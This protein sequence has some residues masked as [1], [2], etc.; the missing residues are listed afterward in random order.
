M[1]CICKVSC[2]FVS[3]DLGRCHAVDRPK[4]AGAAA[5]EQRG[6][7]DGMSAAPQLACD[8]SMIRCA[9]QVVA[10]CPLL[11]NE[12]WSVPMSHQRVSALDA[13]LQ[14][15][16]ALSQKHRSPLG[17]PSF[18][19][20]CVSKPS[21]H[22]SLKIQGVRRQGHA[23]L[24]TFSCIPITASCEGYHQLQIGS[25]FGQFDGAINT[26]CWLASAVQRTVR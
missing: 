26:W 14:L 25:T 16:A 17:K 23:S 24:A 2:C 20:E 18:T 3:L 10:C 8:G 13:A 4:A 9:L 7:Q 19:R 5:L 6:L 15:P 11:L 12:F 1:Y 22:Y 21:C